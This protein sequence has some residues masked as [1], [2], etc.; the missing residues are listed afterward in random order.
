M[1]CSPIS[2]SSTIIASSSLFVLEYLLFTSFLLGFDISCSQV[3]RR[4]DVT[5]TSRRLVRNTS[6]G[7]HGDSSG[8]SHRDVKETRPEGT[9]HRDVTE[10]RQEHV[11]GTSRRLVRNTSQGRQ[12]DS[13][14]AHHRRRHGDSSGTRH[15]DV[16][17][18]RQEH[19]TGDVTYPWARRA[20]QLKEKF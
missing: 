20:E 17:E 8:T 15:R 10:T 6:Q 9:R 3:I 7:R 2:L 13:S 1:M 19:V 11:T 5:G 12:G 18:T 16:K 14:G 4:G